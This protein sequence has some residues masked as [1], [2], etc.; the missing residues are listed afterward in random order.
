[1]R[2][3]MAAAQVK[4]EPLGMSSLNIGKKNS[5]ENDPDDLVAGIAEELLALKP[6][7]VDTLFRVFRKL[8]RVHETD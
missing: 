2:L 8:R 1:M 6:D 3:G 5:A 7:A 4:P